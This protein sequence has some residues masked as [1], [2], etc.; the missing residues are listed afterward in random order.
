MTQNTTNF[1]Q[2]QTEANDGKYIIDL[3]ELK[4]KIICIVLTDRIICNMAGSE[5]NY[6]HF[7][8]GSD[9]NMFK[10]NDM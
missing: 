1:K 4:F 8:L 6:N 5:S 7:Y 3:I 9:D 10:A 2:N